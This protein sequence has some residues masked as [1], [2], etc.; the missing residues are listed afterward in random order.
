MLDRDEAIY[1]LGQ[2]QQGKMNQ[3][4]QMVH[5]R[6]VNSTICI[7]YI[8]SIK[9]Y[10]VFWDNYSPTTFTDNPMETAFDSQA[11]DCADYYFMYGENADGVVRCMR[12]LTGQVQMN[13]LWTYGFWQSRERYQ[14]QEELLD[15]VKKYRELGVPLDGII[16]DWQYWGT[17]QKDWNAVEFGNP[18]FPNPQKMMEDVH[19]MNAHIIASVWPS[20]GNNTNIYKELN[21]KNLLLDFKTFPES[22][23]VYDTFNPEARNIYWDYMNKNLFAKGMDGWWLDA[24]EPEFFDNDDKLNQKRMPVYTGRCLMLF[25]LYR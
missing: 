19:K 2:L 8:Q 6:N 10:S 18:L 3:R 16:Q 21:S 11:G 4:N 9:G 23:K 22:A 7:P 14:S 15:V 24:T 5:L 1:G 20:F 12:D 25:L 17:D 13:A